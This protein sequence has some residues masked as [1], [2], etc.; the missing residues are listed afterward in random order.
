MASSVKDNKEER[1]LPVVLMID[2]GLTTERR[3]LAEWL[4]SSR[5]S[6]CNAIDIF[7]AIGEMADFTVKDRPDVIVLDTDACQDNL[8]LLKSVFQTEVLKLSQHRARTYAR[9]CFEGDL[10]AVTDRLKKLIPESP[11]TN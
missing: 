10:N 3:A 11:T 1:S 5:F 8:S 4:E 6:T 9:D 7:D 2:R